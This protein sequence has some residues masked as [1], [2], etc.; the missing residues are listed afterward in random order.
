[1]CHAQNGNW[2]EWKNSFTHTHTHTRGPIR[3]GEA[4]LYKQK[5]IHI[6][7]IFILILWKWYQYT[8]VVH[9]YIH[10][11]IHIYVYMYMYV[12]PS[13]TLPS[14]GGMMATTNKECCICCCVGVRRSPWVATP[15][16]WKTK[17]MECQRV[18]LFVVHW[19]ASSVVHNF[20]LTLVSSHCRRIKNSNIDM[21]FIFIMSGCEICKIYILIKSVIIIYFYI[22]L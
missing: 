4:T 11:Y 16:D 14:I 22:K 7:H 3:C 10:T 18:N 2:L 8:K 6:R 21:R 15:R 20:L 17:M 1:M 12:S 9:T 13:S 19:C 5:L